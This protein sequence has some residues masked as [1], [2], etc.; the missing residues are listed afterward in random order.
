MSSSVSK[1]FLTICFLALGSCYLVKPKVQYFVKNSDQL[2]IHLKNEQ[3][4]SFGDSL[5]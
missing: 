5:F 1:Y 2:S 3:D 4:I